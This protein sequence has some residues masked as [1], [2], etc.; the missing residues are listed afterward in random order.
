MFIS[1]LLPEPL[2]PMIAINSPSRD[3]EAHAAQR[4]HLDRAHVIGLDDVLDVNAH[5]FTVVQLK[6]M[7]GSSQGRR[8]SSAGL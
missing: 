2:G 1:V 4:V 8:N 5:R 3:L 6:P 7:A